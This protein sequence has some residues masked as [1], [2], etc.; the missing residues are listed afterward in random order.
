MAEIKDLQDRVAALEAKANGRGSPTPS[1]TTSEPD[2]P[3][4]PKPARLQITN[5]PPTPQSSP[6]FR[7]STELR[8]EIYRLAVPEEKWIDVDSS[9]YARPA[10]FNTC[11]EIYFEALP[12]FYADYI[13][14]ANTR[15]FDPAVIT[16][17]YEETKHF[18]NEPHILPRSTW[19]PHW[20]N[21]IDWLKGYHA[22]SLPKQVVSKGNMSRIQ[23]YQEEIV[24]SLFGTAF[25]LRRHPWELARRILEVSRPALVALD[26]RWKHDH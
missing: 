19:N 5:S 3:Q 23:E 4:P 24:R 26:A 1:T 18:Q 7:L 25:M 10:L 20:S 14:C 22:G 15:N 13:F 21:L 17:W 16:H 8:L 11:K 9:G 12:S 2:T 6:F